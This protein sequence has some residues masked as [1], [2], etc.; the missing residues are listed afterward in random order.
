MSLL[1]RFPGFKTKA[2]TL[3]YDDGVCY[4]KPLIEIMS[5]YGL[6]GT[7]N[8]NSGFIAKESGGRKLSAAEAIDLYDGSGNEVAVHGERHLSLGVVDPAVAV[9][10]VIRD[11]EALEDIFGRVIKGMAYANGSV[12]DSVVEILKNCGI[13]YSRTTVSTEKTAVPTDWLRMPA[14]CHHN[15]PRLME[16][17][18]KFLEEKPARYYWGN[19]AQLLYVW[20]HSYEFNDN[21]NW[22]VIENFCKHVGG[23]DNV[24]YATNGEIYDYVKAYK[25]LRVSVN[26]KMIHNP[27]A[28]D[29]YV[30]DYGKDVL[31]KGGE[32][33]KID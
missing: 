8:I 27:T 30:N 29:V 17:T 4:D 15:N 3:S 20:G 9:R 1:L 21:D 13:E 24:F 11:R 16:I 2:V 19:Q 25:S 26:G 5:K 6:K 31:I 10:D 33:V 23:R 14:T 22:S 12:S 32:F 7:F 28:T 18:E